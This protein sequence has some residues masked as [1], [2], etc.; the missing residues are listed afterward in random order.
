[1]IPVVLRLDLLDHADFKRNAGV[2][3]P[4][5]ADDHFHADAVVV[6]VQV[7]SHQ[8]IG[9][10]LAWCPQ[11]EG[12]VVD[13][14]QLE[15]FPDP[16]DRLLVLQNQRESTQILVEGQWLEVDEFK[17]VESNLIGSAVSRQ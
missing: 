9:R 3:H 10:V 7:D 11:L 13:V 14:G 12:A 16:L 4:D 1:L 15:R 8:M 6:G 5:G 17:L 2:E